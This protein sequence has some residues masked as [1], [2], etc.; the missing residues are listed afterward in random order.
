MPPPGV[1]THHR[2]VAEHVCREQLADATV[3]GALRLLHQEVRPV[4][5]RPSHNDGREQLHT[6]SY[7]HAHAHVHTCTHTH[8]QTH[9]R[10]HTT[11]HTTTPAGLQEVPEGKQQHRMKRHPPPMTR[12]VHDARVAE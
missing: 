9:S 6:N 3:R 2:N 1:S 8:T 11:T 12:D 7:T 5:R 10:T 4:P